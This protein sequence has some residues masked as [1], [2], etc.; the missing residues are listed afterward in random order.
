MAKWIQGMGLKEGA[1][2]RQLGVPEGKKI[3]TS[4]L[5]EKLRAVK[6]KMKKGKATA[7]DRRLFRRLMIALRAK[8]GWKGSV[9]TKALQ[10]A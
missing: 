4:L 6:A 3:P 2:H 8:M 1:L 9:L 5:V 10:R 7:E